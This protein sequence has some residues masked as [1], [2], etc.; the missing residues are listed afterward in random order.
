MPMDSQMCF[1]HSIEKN[2]ARDRKN[3]IRPN[4]PPC[5]GGFGHGWGALGHN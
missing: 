4:P 3:Q 5:V 2:M 1:Y